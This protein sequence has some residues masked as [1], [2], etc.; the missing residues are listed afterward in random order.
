M[1]SRLCG[2]VHN[3]RLIMHCYTVA[4]FISDTL[5]SGQKP[6]NPSLKAFLHVLPHGPADKDDSGGCGV[7]G[8]VLPPKDDNDESRGPV[9]QPATAAASCHDVRRDTGPSYQ[10]QSPAMIHAAPGLLQTIADQTKLI[11][12]ACNARITA[13][14]MGRQLKIDGG[15]QNGDPARRQPVPQHKR[16]VCKR[17]EGCGLESSGD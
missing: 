8:H 10:P 2:G 6:S 4:P 11:P 12:L 13:A 5:I 7:I 16:V 17:L 14:R 9:G 1:S 15:G 3:A